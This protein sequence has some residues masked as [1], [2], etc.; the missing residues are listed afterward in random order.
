[1]AKYKDPT[2]VARDNGAIFD[3]KYGPGAAVPHSGIYR[4]NG[5]RKEMACNLGDPL[6][7]QDRHQHG[8]MQGPVEWQLVVATNAP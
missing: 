4:C 8:L 2:S 6:P 3:V 5:C 1:M 7:S